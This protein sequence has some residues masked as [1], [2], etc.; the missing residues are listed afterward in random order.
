LTKAFLHQEKSKPKECFV[1]K[2]IFV[3]KVKGMIMPLW[4]EIQ[5]LFIT[6]EFVDE[7]LPSGLSSNLLHISLRRG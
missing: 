4:T 7:F 2:E 1:Y 6:L 3:L 5:L